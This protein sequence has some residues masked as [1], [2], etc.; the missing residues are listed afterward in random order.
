MLQNYQYFLT[1]AETLNISQ[2]AKQLLQVMI[3]QPKLGDSS[4]RLRPFLGLLRQIN[5]GV[6]A[7]FSAG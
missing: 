2:A 5:H 1:L 6:Q 3:G 7:V 4:Q